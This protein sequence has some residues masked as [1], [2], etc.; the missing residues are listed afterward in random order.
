[1]RKTVRKDTKRTAAKKRKFLKSEVGSIVLIAAGIFLILS[2]LGLMGA[3]GNAVVTVQKGLAGT[4]YPLIGLFIGAA[5]AIAYMERG[6]YLMKFKVAG[7]TAAFLAIVSIVQLLFGERGAGAYSAGELYSLGAGGALGGG[8]IGGV[9]AGSFESVIGYVGTYFVLIVIVIIA[10]VIITEKSFVNAARIG[11][12]KTADALRTGAE[13]TMVAAREGRER[14]NEHREQRRIRHREEKEVVRREAADHDRYDLGG[15]DAEAYIRYGRE[16][17]GS[18]Q[19]GIRD[20]GTIKEPLIRRKY[21]SSIDTSDMNFD[22]GVITSLPEDIGAIKK[23]VS[24]KEINYEEDTV[25]F[26]ADK[27]EKYRSYT[28]ILKLGVLSAETAGMH[29]FAAGRMPDED[30][31]R[32][33]AGTVSGAAES[34]DAFKEPSEEGYHGI[35]ISGMDDADYM[36]EEQPAS[37]EPVN[38]H[39][40]GEQGLTGNKDISYVPETEDTYM[41][42]TGKEMESPDAYEASRILDEKL[43]QSK[44]SSVARPDEGSVSVSQDQ[45]KKD[46][47]NPETAIKPKPRPYRFPGAE[48]LVRGKKGGQGG[49]DE[50][51]ANARKLERVLKEFGVGVTVT[52]VIRGPR[53][54][55]YEMIPDTGIKVSRIT[56]LEGD[57]KLALAAAELRIEAPIPG[58]SA[59]GIEVPNTESQTV[60]FRDILESDEFKNAKSKLI[61]GIGLDI[62]GKPVVADIAKM[63][64]VLV[65]GTTGSGKSVGINSLIMSI[66]Y[67]SSPEDVRMIL[68]DPKVVE[69]SVYNG[70]PHLL[71]EVVT[72]PEKAISALNWAVAEMNNRYK[73]FQQSATRNIAGYNEKVEKTLSRL[74]EDTDEEKKPKKLPY[75]LIVIDELSE[76]MMHSKKDVE[77]AIVS[78]TQLARASGI[79]IVIATQ[80]PSVDVITGVIKSNIPSR[81]AYR[82]PSAV[83]SRTILDAGG[84]ETLL[85]NG[86]MLYKPGDKNSPERI[87]GAFLSDEEVESVVDFIRKNNQAADDGSGFEEA[88][89]S[90]IELD[91]DAISGGTESGR[92]DRDEYFGDAGRMIISSKKASIGALQRKFKVGFNRAARIMDQLHDAGVV[93]DSE[94]TKERQI[95]M[96]L[97]AFEALLREENEV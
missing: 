56:A 53:V 26:E 18:G 40:G 41:T 24:I 77:A 82:L 78:L 64:H 30:M 32:N 22:T 81:I 4:A 12:E 31:Q 89:N 60:R 48:L 55:R 52:N 28:D 33:M 74:P 76:L 47:L 20:L 44:K 7:L 65:A 97:D 23:P 5:A 91:L 6:R 46:A 37:A 66:L 70:I 86:D 92:L 13:K 2:D 29:G 58:K 90:Q 87:Q 38:E 54:S 51:V 63:P 14:Y 34:F 11:A 71:T 61:W 94:G 79:H 88:I 62:Q 93:G 50:A 84:A 10:V 75:I 96:D 95:L 17:I 72:K 35:S 25:P 83:D 67:R 85:G 36:S 19:P 68:I 43:G 42:S 27:S 8:A 1:M 3:A 57:I 15:H 21:R 16:I 49:R 9:I 39:A 73:L 59:V 80:R 45:A 69:L